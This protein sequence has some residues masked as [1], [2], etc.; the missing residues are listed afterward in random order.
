[1]DAT[2]TADPPLNGHAL[3]MEWLRTKNAQKNQAAAWVLCRV[4]PMSIEFLVEEALKPGNRP[5]HRVRILDVIQQIGGPL[6]AKE[7]YAIAK[8]QE[9]SAAKVRDKAAEVLRTL[10]PDGPP[11]LVPPE[12][13]A[14][15]M[16]LHPARVFQ[17]AEEI[18]RRALA[19][20]RQREQ[21]PRRNKN[22]LARPWWGI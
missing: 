4:G 16:E 1:M 15:A 20:R 5:D 6:K 3:L 22:R 17:R 9:Y 7:Y 21:N 14:A 10:S 12:V 18:G 2:P 19:A 13:M 11:S 8:L